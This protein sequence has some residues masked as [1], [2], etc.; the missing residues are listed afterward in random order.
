MF[1]ITQQSGLCKKPGEAT[2]EKRWKERVMQGFIITLSRKG[3][4]PQRDSAL[5]QG[6]PVLALFLFF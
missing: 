4:F 1:K 5:I 3:P 2:A 6:Q